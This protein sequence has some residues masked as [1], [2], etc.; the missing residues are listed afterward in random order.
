MTSRC[1][2]DEPVDDVDVAPHV[3]EEMHEVLGGG[4]SVFEGP[5]PEHDRAALALE[6][7]EVGVQVN[8]KVR[9]RLRLPTGC[10]EGEAVERARTL[11]EVRPHLAEKLI[12]KTVWVPGRLVNFVLR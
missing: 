4:S 5:W 8:G 6:E 12:V 1:G 10:A 2:D 7:V 9:G 3:G 11:P